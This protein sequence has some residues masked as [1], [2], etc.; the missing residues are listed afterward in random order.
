MDV[1]IN[2]E[3]AQELLGRYGSPLY[4]YSEKILRER[5]R[6]LLKA[7]CGRIKPS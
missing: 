1:F 3:T 5:C 4:V 7:F 2:L 6:D